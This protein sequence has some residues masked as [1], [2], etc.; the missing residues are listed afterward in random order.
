MPSKLS[1][2]LAKIQQNQRG[3]ISVFGAFLL[4]LCVGSYHGTF[5]NLLPYLTSYLRKVKVLY[6][7]LRQELKE[8]NLRVSVRPVYV[9]LLTNYLLT[10]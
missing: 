6:F 3:L 4:Q 2:C 5:G 10:Y 8:S 1:D 7:W 9:C